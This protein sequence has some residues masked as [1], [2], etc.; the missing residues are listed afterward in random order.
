M[1]LVLESD[2]IDLTTIDEISDILQKVDALNSEI[3]IKERG[4]NAHETLLDCYVL[5][6]ASSILKRCIQTVNI[7]TTPYI[8]SEFSLGIISSIKNDGKNFKPMNY[9][10]VFKSAKDLPPCIKHCSSVYGLYDPNNLPKPKQKKQ[11]EKIE[12]EIIQKKAPENIL[13]AEN[14]E[15]GIEGIVM[16]F[17]EV[18]KNAYAKNNQSPINY[19]DYIIDTSYSKTIENMFYFAFLVRDGKAFLDLNVKGIPVIKPMSSKE[20]TSFRDEGGKN[21][22]LISS[23]SMDIWE[24]HKKTGLLQQYRE[25]S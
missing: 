13:I 12:Q 7:S 18:L 6:S 21:T 15:E 10:K 3:D 23:I 22:Q 25:A 20:L 19:Y 11:K 8:S 2:N 5:T 24:E 17:F 14:E 16:V 9:M 4:G 1:Q